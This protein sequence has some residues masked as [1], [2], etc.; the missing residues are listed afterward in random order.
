MIGYERLKSAASIT[1]KTLIGSYG[2][3]DLVE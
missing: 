1:D 3:T 2:S